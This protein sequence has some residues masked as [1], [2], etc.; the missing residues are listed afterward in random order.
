MPVTVTATPDGN[1][2]VAG[3]S[4]NV[5]ITKGYSYLVKVD[6]SGSVLWKKTYTHDPNMTF[7]LTDASPNSDGTIYIAGIERK[8][9][10]TFSKISILALLDSTGNYLWSTSVTANNAFASVQKIIPTAANG[11]YISG[12]LEGELDK[13]YVF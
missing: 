11:C 9:T 1:L 7:D 10:E 5:I 13:I 12:T 6:T 2:L 3:I 4:R 8:R